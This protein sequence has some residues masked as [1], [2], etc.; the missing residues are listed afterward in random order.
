MHRLAHFGQAVWQAFE[1]YG[2]RRSD[3]ELLELADRWRD[4]NPTLAR[5][6]RSHVR[7]GSSY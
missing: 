2:R 4:A 6:L 1:E 7:G 5:E 3:R